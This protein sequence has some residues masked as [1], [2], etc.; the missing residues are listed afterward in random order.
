MQP[1][2]ANFALASFMVGLTVC[3]HFVGL[4]VDLDDAQE[5]TS[6]SSA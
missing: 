4:L 1:M 6:S 3:I 2:F 5:R